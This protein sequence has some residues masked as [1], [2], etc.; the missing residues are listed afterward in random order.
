MW[1]L[2]SGM[3]RCPAPHP[4]PQSVLSHDGRAV[5]EE[6]MPPPKTG[7]ADEEGEEEAEPEREDADPSVLYQ[8]RQ[9]DHGSYLAPRVI[10]CDSEQNFGSLGLSGRHGSRYDQGEGPA[11]DPLSWGGGVMQAASSTGP[12][13]TCPK[14]SLAGGVK[15]DC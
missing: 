1:E 2:T 14:D 9:D 13:P 15:R 8:Q 4:A 11:M 3:C 10:V 5:Q 12:N 7:R 6:A